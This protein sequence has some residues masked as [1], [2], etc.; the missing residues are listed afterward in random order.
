M[1]RILLIE[2]DE[3]VRHAVGAVL[4]KAGH[5]V[6]EAKDGRQGLHL[7]AAGDHDLYITDIVMPQAEGIEVIRAIREMGREQPVIAISGGGRIDKLEMLRWAGKFGATETLAKP[8]TM[9]ELSAAVARS[10]ASRPPQR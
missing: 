4:R 10:L 7:I 6:E 2:D 5:D 8:F 1:A 9:Q 3:I